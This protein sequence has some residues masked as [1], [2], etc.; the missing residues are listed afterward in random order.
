MIRLRARLQRFL[1]LSR[2]PVNDGLT[3]RPILVFQMAKVAS[4]SWF[5]MLEEAFPFRKVH[6]F[7]SISPFSLGQIDDV[8]AR[9][10]PEQTI[11]YL[12]LPRLGR[13]PQTIAHLAHQGVWHGPAVDIVAGMRDPIARAASVVAFLS[14][15]LGYLRTPVTVRDGGGPE[16]LRALFF[17]VLRAA[18][19]DRYDGGDTLVET[20][21]HAVFDYRRWFNEELRAGFGLDVTTTHFD[22]DAGALTITGQ[23]NLLVYRVEDLGDP[24]VARRMMATADK[25]LGGTLSAVPAENTTGEARF[26]RLYRA[27][28]ADLHFEP[29]DLDW[30]YD[31]DTV[32]HFYSAA[33]IAA[34]RARWS[35]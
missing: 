9:K 2:T 22:R 3:E 23:H 16:T 10:G 1:A 24:K 21:T 28:L 4:R 6:H 8:V 18:Q 26:Q 12:S 35:R 20:L 29:A 13:P 32:R 7:H 17:N 31:D 19:R 27:F 33:E 14:N 5:M 34:F 25:V 30:F 11:R 15:R